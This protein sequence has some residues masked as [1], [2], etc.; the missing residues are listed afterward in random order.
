LKRTDTETTPTAPTTPTVPTT[1]E[2]SPTPS[3]VKTPRLKTSDRNKIIADYKT[4]TLHPD[5]EIITTKVEGKY[6]VRPRK[7]QLTEEQIQKVKPKVVEEAPSSLP[8]FSVPKKANLTEEGLQSQCQLNFQLLEEMKN[9][10]K[11]IKKLKH[12]VFD[13]E[14]LPE[15]APP[16][17]VPVVDIEA[18]IELSPP[19]VVEEE[20]P[21]PEPEVPVQ[22]T[23]RFYSKAELLN[24]K[25]FGF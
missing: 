13:E 4:G 16:K 14:D 17:S 7:I 18:P 12:R 15:E 11:K 20:L 2:A 21:P 24:Y 6:I 23:R 10:K 25:R 1:P 22:R 3:S 19:T 5:F 8:S 9:L